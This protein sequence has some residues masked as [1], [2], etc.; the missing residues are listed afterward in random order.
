M[1]ILSAERLR[2]LR[3]L[4]RLLTDPDVRA[5]LEHEQVPGL[6]LDHLTA[7]VI[8]LLEER[9][10]P[11][12]VSA[13]Q[14]AV[15]LGIVQAVFDHLAVWGRDDGELRDGAVG[16]AAEWLRSAAIGRPD[17]SEHAVTEVPE[18]VAEPA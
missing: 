6:L 9:A 17:R 15:F 1:W 14:P 2:V 10:A 8:D 3:A 13:G 12:D 11:L 5:R 16:F 18:A 4:E 7:A